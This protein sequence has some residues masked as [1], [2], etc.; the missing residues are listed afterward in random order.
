MPKFDLVKSGKVVAV[1]DIDASESVEHIISVLGLS[2]VVVSCSH[3]DSHGHIEYIHFSGIRRWH[4]H[5]YLFKQS[6]TMSERASLLKH[7]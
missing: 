4:P 6:L 5:Y 3:T 1:F 2:N 7:C